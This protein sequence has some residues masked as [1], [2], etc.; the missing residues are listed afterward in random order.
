MSDYQTLL[1]IHVAESHRIS[2]M[3]ITLAP[4]KTGTGFP[5]VAVEAKLREMLIDAAEA[6]AAIS[7]TSL[8]ADVPGK[9]AAAVR[10]D[11]LHVVSLLCDVEPIAGLELKDSLVR[12]GGYNSVNH[13]ME[14]LMPRIE[15]YWEKHASKGDKT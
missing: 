3:A 5:K 7:G 10:L 14:H 4:P 11:S 15:K 6:D 9:C 12:A 1:C 2:G 8:P 13:A